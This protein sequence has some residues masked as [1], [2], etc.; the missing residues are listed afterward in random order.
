MKVLE[1]LNKDGTADL[2]LVLSP[3]ESRTLRGAL[4]EVCFGFQ[5][6]DFDG[7]LGCTQDQA[8]ALFK[9]LDAL[10]LDRNNTITILIDELRAIRNA[11][12]ETLRTLG[13]EEFQTRV[14]VHFIEG[15]RIGRELDAVLVQAGHR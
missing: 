1:P 15:E 10:D 14:G 6:S 2:S 9:R 7:I 11:H 8:R 3:T 13:V 12:V 4:G 5:V